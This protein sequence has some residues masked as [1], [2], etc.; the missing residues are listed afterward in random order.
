MYTSVPFYLG[1]TVDDGRVHGVLI[2]H[3]GRVEMDI[4]KTNEA[5]VS[6]TVQGDSLIAY[7]FAGPTPA[8]VLRQ[9]TELTGR[10]SLPPL[11]AIGDHLCRWAYMAQQEVRP[12]AA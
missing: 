1:L 12:M 4:G 11:W 10:M 6:M 5:E 7:F 8:D 2:D 9:Y 3:T